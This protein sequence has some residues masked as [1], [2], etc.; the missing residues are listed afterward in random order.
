VTLIGRRQ[1]LQLA[2]ATAGLAAV[3][4]APILPASSDIGPPLVQPGGT[5]RIA[6]AGEPPTGDPLSASASTQVLCGLVYSRLLRPRAGAGVPYDS[7]EVIEDL[8]EKWEQVDELVHVFY[9]RRGVR[10]QDLPPVFGREVVA[11]DARLSLE[12]LLAQR[13]M[14][15]P[16]AL[17]AIDRIEL[18]DRYTIKLTLR[19]PMPAIVSA[20]ASPQARILPAE[21][22]E[23]ELDLRRHPIGSGPF[24]LPRPDRSGRLV[25][26]KNPSY[27]RA[28]QPFLDAVEL[29]IVPD[30]AAELALLK[31]RE[32]DLGI[33]PSGLLQSEADALRAANPDL[34][35]SR[36]HRPTVV[37]LGFN[38]ARAPFHDVRLRQAVSL[39]LDR[40]RL[41][42]D[43]YGEN[44]VLSG[45]VPP[46]LAEWTLGPDE[47]ERYWGRRDV[48]RARALWADAAPI[49]PGD[50]TL[51]VHPSGDLGS[52]ADAIVEQLR[53]AGIRVR[54]LRPDPAVLGRVVVDRAFDLILLQP[55]PSTEFDDWTGAL[56]SSNSPR[57]FWGYVDR[58]FD[59][60]LLRTRRG[61]DRELRRRAA[62]ELQRY[63]AD[64]LPV[65]PLF[66]PVHYYAVASQVKGWA[67]HWSAGLP[68]L[69]EAWIARPPSAT[70]T[71]RG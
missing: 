69:D 12:R 19:E 47:L 64:K 20:L 25:L 32:S 1:F 55:A 6:I 5:L 51:L 68:S 36:V 61:P 45:H 43:A 14:A 28:S 35:I 22:V 71:S 16:P 53:E 31:N 50:L 4:C 46:S 49:D 58:R 34:V 39:A 65:A 63:L 66:S 67:P 8:A 10:W 42:S 60:L 3:R 15:S 23:R 48:A 33:E 24:L 38:D 26:R 11:D 29:L 57:N 37:L 52:L 9:L 18:P 62:L 54:P 40:R 2:G 21:L 41:G 70:P 7:G 27:F 44:Y 59:E 13:T 17:S 30:R 56:Y